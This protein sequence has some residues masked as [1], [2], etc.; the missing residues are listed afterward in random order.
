MNKKFPKNFLWGVAYSSHQVEGNNENNWTD[1]E[2]KG[3]PEEK[4]GVA[5]DSWN[6]YK[7]DHKLANDLGCGGF[8]LS[9]EWSRIEPEEGKFSKE[10]LDHYRKILQNIKKQGMKRVVTLWHWT[11]PIWFEENCGWHKKESVEYFS[12]YCAKVMKE[13]GDEIDIFLTLNEPANPLVQGYLTG[14]FPPGKRNVFLCSKAKNNFIKAHKNCYEIVKKNFPRLPVGITQ[15]CIT[16]ET[17]K[18][19]FF[20]A[21]IIKKIQNYFNWHFFDGSSEY[22]DFI[23]VNYYTTYFLSLIPPFSVRKTTKGRRTDMGWGVYPQG[24]KEVLIDAKKRFERPIYILENGLADS[25][26]K[27]RADYIEEYLEK[28]HEAIEEGA[29]IKGY[30]YW[31]L[32]DNFEWNF[33]YGPKFGLCAIEKKTLDR[34]PRKSYFAYQKIIKNK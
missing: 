25:E 16:L 8:R 28:V 6:R 7:E 34:K 22:H 33:G 26:D 11:S 19:L 17:G 32:L 15:F 21:P 3:R 14:S 20:L 12:K 9:L 31:S 4:S 5:C 30:F 29:D 24:I 18:T 1:W 27:Y 13:L 23:G 2:E 10:A